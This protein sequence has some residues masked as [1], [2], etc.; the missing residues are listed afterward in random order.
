MPCR[1]QTAASCTAQCLGRRRHPGLRTARSCRYLQQQRAAYTVSGRKSLRY[2]RH[3]FGG[4]FKY[5][6]IIFGTRRPENPLY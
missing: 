3:I 5:A 1:K 2:S 4:T 6:F